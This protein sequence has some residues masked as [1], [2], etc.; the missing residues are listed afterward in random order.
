MTEPVGMRDLELSQLLDHES[1]RD[2]IAE[3]RWYGAKARSIAG[4]EIVEHLPLRQDPPLVLALVQTRFA[5]GTHELYQL[6]L[7]LM[8]AGESVDGGG[9]GPCGAAI[10]SGDDWTVYDGLADPAQAWELLRMIGAGE[11]ADTEHGRFS[12][13][14]G[15]ELSLID[16]EGLARL[17]GVEQSNS[18]VVF[19]DRLVLKVFRKLEPGI[20]PELEMLRFLQ[21]HGFEHIAPLQGYYE[22]EG[23]ALA[24]TL[25]V[26]QTFLPDAVGGWELALEEIPRDPERFLGRL[27]SLGEI[28]ARMHTALATDAGDPAFSPEEPSQEM[29]SLLTATVDEDIERIFVRLPDSDAVAPIAGRGQDVRERLAARAQIGTGGR[30]TRTHGDYHLGQTLSTPRNWVIIDFEGEPARP[31]P[32]RRQKRSPLRD[33]AGMLRSFAYVSSAVEMM[34]G[35]RAPEDFEQRARE[36][37]LGQYLEHVDATLLPAGEAAIA[38]LL[39]IYELEKAIYELQYELNNRPDWVPIPVAGI[40]RLLEAS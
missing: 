30:V 27:A 23:Q 34:A 9:D 5:T 37:F 36:C 22:Y 13:H 26:V 12:F 35:P 29:L 15:Q 25:G 2:W 8:R 18:S 24:A 11:G 7:V 31:L 40:R 3:Q 6:P 28:T 19:E 21:G 14:A 16:P 4:V 10:T 33:V 32:E 38:N 20:N 17:M 1:L 39:S